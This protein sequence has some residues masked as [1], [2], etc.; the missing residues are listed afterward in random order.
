MGFYNAGGK[1]LSMAYLLKDIHTKNSN[2]KSVNAALKNT[3]ER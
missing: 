2:L 3:D 1:S